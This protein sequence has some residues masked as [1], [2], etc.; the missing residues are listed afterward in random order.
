MLNN[1]ILLVTENRTQN[2]N[3]FSYN[4]VRIFVDGDYTY[5]YWVSEKEIYDSL[6]EV[7]KKQYLTD[8]SYAGGK[9]EV[10]KATAQHLI[11]IGQTPYNKVKL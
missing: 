6:N 10:D 9:F 8:N 5:G 1:H 2:P 7:Q 4:T 3:R 11:D